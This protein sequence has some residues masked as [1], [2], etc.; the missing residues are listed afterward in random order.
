MLSGVLQSE[1]AVEINIE[2]I[3]AFVKLPQ[4]IASNAELGSRL[5]H[6]ERNTFV[7]TFVDT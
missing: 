2:I 1:L 7:D 5:T 4:L 3:R 6:L